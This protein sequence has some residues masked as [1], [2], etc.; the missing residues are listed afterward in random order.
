M[1]AQR[2]YPFYTDMADIKAMLESIAGKQSPSGIAAENLLTYITGFD[3]EEVF[4]E[5]MDDEIRMEISELLKVDI[6][7]N[8][9]N[10]E[11]FVQISTEYL[12]ADYTLSIFDI[13][14]KLLMETSVNINT[15]NSINIKTLPK[16]IFFVRINMDT[17]MI[18][19]EKIIK[20]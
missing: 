9:A 14:G 4:D 11:L 7:P 12:K 2:T 17:Q 5:D 3:Y 13:T 10:N 8:P 18:H 15:M 1:A 19:V 20:E 16:G 6:F